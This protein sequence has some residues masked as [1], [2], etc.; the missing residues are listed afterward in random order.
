ME[1]IYSSRQIRSSCQR[2]INFIWLLD[3]A[4]APSYHEIARFRSQRLS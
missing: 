3:G 1:N 2:D 4:A